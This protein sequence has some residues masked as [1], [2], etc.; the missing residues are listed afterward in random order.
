MKIYNFCS[1]SL[2]NPLNILKMYFRFHLSE[3]SKSILKY[4]F[5]KAYVFSQHED[6]V[7]PIFLSKC[8]I[9]KIY[10]IMIYEGKNYKRLLKKF[11]FKD[12]KKIN[13]RIKFKFIILKLLQNDKKIKLSLQKNKLYTFIHFKVIEK[14]IKF[15]PPSL[16]KITILDLLSK[17]NLSKKKIILFIDSNEEKVVGSRY[18]VVT[19][20]ILKLASSL[21]YHIVV[22][23]HVRENLSKS[24]NWYTDWDYLVEPLP[25]ELYDLKKVRIV[26]GMASA[27]LATIAN[28]YPKL[29]C[30]STAKLI[31]NNKSAKKTIM[32]L[33]SICSKNRLNYPSNIYEFTKLISK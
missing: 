18:S 1:S 25:I 10:Q 30:V 23:K 14:K 16:C 21:K 28:K 20:K 8:K 26:L 15:L 19:N 13:L 7:A 12:Q 9:K 31:Q 5:D 11:P 3:D 4:N 27:A 6:F 32:E 17:K 22:K 2:K 33:N 24:V 29:K